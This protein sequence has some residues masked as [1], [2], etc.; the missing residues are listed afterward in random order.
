MAKDKNSFQREERNLIDVFN[1]LQELQH[2]PK[3]RQSYQRKLHKSKFAIHSRLDSNKTYQKTYDLKLSHIILGC[4]IL[5]IGMAIFFPKT[6]AFTESYAKEE[7]IEA[8][9]EYGLWLYLCWNLEVWDMPGCAGDSGLYRL[10]DA[11]LSIS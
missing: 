8:V 2:N 4:S 10:P 6:S 3:A 5:I 9:S 1:E 11:F 7:K